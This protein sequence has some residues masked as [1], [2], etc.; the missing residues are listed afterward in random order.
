M[1]Q[2]RIKYVGRKPF[3]TDNVARS[4]KQWA[5]RGD[6]QEVTEAQ[7]K[8]L[9]R[10]PDQWGVDDGS[11]LPDDA[12]ITEALLAVTPLAGSSI[13]LDDMTP[14]ELVAHGEKFLGLTLDP[15]WPKEDILSL[16]ND[17]ERNARIDE[18]NERNKEV[19]KQDGNV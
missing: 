10:Y 9:C 4:G 18:E 8:I 13:S 6:V 17:A 1:D 19:V 15:A 12:A 2:V 11:P 5:G 16:I 7:A 14:E 3:A